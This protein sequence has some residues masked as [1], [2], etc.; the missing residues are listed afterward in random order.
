[1]PWHRSAGV[2]AMPER[3]ASATTIRLLSLLLALLL[4]TFVT[5]ERP[6]ERRCSVPVRCRNVAPGLAATGAPPS[7]EAVLSGPWL[8]LHLLPPE[9][10]VIDLDCAGAGAGVTAFPAVEQCL[11]LPPALRVTRVSPA[12]IDIRLAPVP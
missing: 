8:S 11:I 12:R 7:V 1:M 6:A 5:G 2:T 9:S 4:W 3:T 10:L